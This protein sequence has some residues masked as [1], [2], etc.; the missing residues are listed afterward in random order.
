MEEADG[1]ESG[2]VGGD[3]DPS[4]S[5]EE[6]GGGLEEPEHSWS[7]LP[8]ASATN[9]SAM[10]ACSTWPLVDGGAEAVASLSAWPLGEGGVEAG[11]SVTKLS[12]DLSSLRRVDV[13]GGSSM[14]LPT[15]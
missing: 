4:S 5:D 13:G 12:S 8:R 3:M 7:F 2:G 11:G 10:A 14:V 1:D 15:T 9:S 6:R